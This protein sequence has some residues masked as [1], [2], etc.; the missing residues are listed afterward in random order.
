M[1]PA[2]VVAAFAAALAWADV[3]HAQTSLSLDAAL[4]R[5]SETHPDLRLISA[6]DTRLA[7]ARETAAMPPDLALEATL[8]NFAGSGEAH[9]LDAAELT[10]GLASHFERGGKREAR[11][12]LVDRE[13]DAVAT[14]HRARRLDL[15]ADVAHRYLAAASAGWREDVAREGAEQHATAR[16]AA[17]KRFTAG[18]SPESSVLAAEATLARAELAQA[19]ARLGKRNAVRHLATLWGELE[20]DF[21]P[22]SNEPPRLPELEPTGT[23]LARLDDSP[24]VARLADSRRIAEAR[25]R[26]AESESRGDLSWQLGLR[27]L[28]GT[29]DTALVAGLSLPLGNTRRAAPSIR[30]AL[31][32]RDALDIE[33]DSLALALRATLIEASGRYDLACE[34]VRR[35]D[36]DVLPRLRAAAVA[37]ERAYR[38]GAGDY[39]DWSQFQSEITDAR[40]E[41]VD[42]VV[43]AL[44]ALIEIQ[45]LAGLPIRFADAGEQP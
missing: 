39:L 15:L 32:E 24:E 8:E 19:R 16:D 14:E 41:R 22:A 7:A 33:R 45:R 35:L 37:A 28:Q 18:A 3:A 23:L 4:Q 42:A 1:H 30:E 44:S 6:R 20:P 5:V 36:A 9:G 2:L 27:R 31:L 40:F 29:R 34:E 38:A 17:L 21:V 25:L 26:M 11:I 13:R 10:L 12:A 43:A